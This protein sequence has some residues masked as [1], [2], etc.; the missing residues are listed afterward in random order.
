MMRVPFRDLGFQ[1]SNKNCVSRCFAKLKLP[2]ERVHFK[3]YT[4][5][6]I[7]GQPAPPGAKMSVFFFLIQKFSFQT[8]ILEMIGQYK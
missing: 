3:V 1:V 8:F 2:R 6:G 7:H 5:R 4:A